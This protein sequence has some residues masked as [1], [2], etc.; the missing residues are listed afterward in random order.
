MNHGMASGMANHEDSSVFL[1]RID[2]E[3][4]AEEIALEDLN[5]LNEGIC[6][7]AEINTSGT[8]ET[9]GE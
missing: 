6:Q 9:R 4:R 8:E 1:P 2:C 3:H 7:A 5:V